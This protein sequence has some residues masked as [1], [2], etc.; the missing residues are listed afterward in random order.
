[1]PRAP[2][3]HGLCAASVPRVCGTASQAKV[4][5]TRLLAEISRQT[6][7][8]EKQVVGDQWVSA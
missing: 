6:G 7:A 8:L 2:T 3:A 5:P 1:M 4:D